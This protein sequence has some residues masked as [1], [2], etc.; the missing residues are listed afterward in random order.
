M[1][2]H[3]PNPSQLTQDSIWGSQCISASY[4]FHMPDKKHMSAGV[5]KKCQTP[6]ILA[7]F[8]SLHLSQPLLQY[9]KVFAS[10]T[11]S[12]SHMKELSGK[13]SE[14]SREGEQVKDGL[15]WFR[16]G[17]LAGNSEPHLHFVA[18]SLCQCK[19]ERKTPSDKHYELNWN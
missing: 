2:R 16:C 12:S 7:S 15:C 5:K 18:F 14:G 3:K 13:Y 17:N 6:C 10:A 19:K 1:C 8:A 4:V 11:F 9:S